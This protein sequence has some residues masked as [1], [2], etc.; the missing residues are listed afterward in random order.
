MIGAIAGD[1]IGS[2][3]EFKNID[4]TLK[5]NFKLFIDNS[6]F[7]DDTVLTIALADCIMNQKDWITTIHEY[8]ERYSNCGFGGSFIP[9]AKDKQREPYNSFGNGSAMRVSPIAWLYEGYDVI[10]GSRKS[11]RVT[12]NHLEGIK[13]AEAI[14]ICIYLSLSGYS[15]SDIHNHITTLYYDEI[16]T[17]ESIPKLYDKYLLEERYMLYSCQGSVP[18][19]IRCFLDGESFEDVIRLAVSIGGDSDTLACMAGG[20]AEA[21][22][23][24]PNEIRDQVYNY[25]DSDLMK[26]VEQFNNEIKIT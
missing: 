9:W 16:P 17:L 25:L 14:A 18:Q 5:D 8:Y 11:A 12:H 23:G 15:K 22:Y 10:N 3:Y 21:F 26:I 19:A 6:R 7:T 2:P 24:I 13:G 20:I 4:P 1:I